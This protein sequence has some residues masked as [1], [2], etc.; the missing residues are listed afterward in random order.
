LILRKLSESMGLSL[1]EM[2]RDRETTCP[3]EI[4][5]EAER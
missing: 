4:H 3:E 2:S 1:T 5:R